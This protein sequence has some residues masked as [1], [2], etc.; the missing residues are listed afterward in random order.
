MDKQKILIVTEGVQAAQMIESAFKRKKEK[1]NYEYYDTGSTISNAS[2][3]S[4]KKKNNNDLFNK[5][6][7]KI[8][9]DYSKNY[10]IKTLNYSEVLIMSDSDDNG[11]QLIGLIY[12]A[13]VEHYPSLLITK[14]VRFVKFPQIIIKESDLSFIEFFTISDFE[15]YQRTT[16]AAE[17]QNY[18]IEW[19]RGLATITPKIADNLFKNLEKYIIYM[20][21]DANRDIIKFKQ[22]FGQSEN[23]KQYR[24]ESVI[25]FSIKIHENSGCF[26]T[27]NY[28][29]NET[30]CADF[31]DYEFILHFY[32]KAIQTLTSMIDG[33]TIP[34]RLVMHAILDQNTTTTP[35]TVT[36]AG[37]VGVL[38]ANRTNNQLKSDNLSKTAASLGYENNIQ[39][40]LN[41]LIPTTYRSK[42]STWKRKNPRYTNTAIDSLSRFIFR[43]EDE[44]ILKYNSQM[45][46]K[47]NVKY[48]L[49]IIP[50]SIVNGKMVRIAIIAYSFIGHKPIEIINYLI[51]RLST[52][53][54][55]FDLMPHFVQYKGDIEGCYMNPCSTGHF[56]IDLHNR[57]II[58]SVLPFGM[59]VKLYIAKTFFKNKILENIKYD[60]YEVKKNTVEIQFDNENFKEVEKLNYE[61]IV[62]IC[63]LRH[64]LYVDKTMYCLNHNNVI[65]NYGKSVQNLID[66]YYNQRLNA[67]IERN[68]F[69][70]NLLIAK[71]QQNNMKLKY[72][73]Q[74]TSPVFDKSIINTRENHIA[75]IKKMNIETDPLKSF[76]NEQF[77]VDYEKYKYV[78]ELPTYDESILLV[79]KEL[80]EQNNE[81]QTI[82]KKTP[83][84]EWIK[85]LKELLTALTHVDKS[86]LNN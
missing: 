79:K 51:K 26:P 24:R 38:A 46:K 72:L 4:D 58:I 22:W 86:N 33:F 21:Y 10:N 66:N 20:K 14:Y 27:I 45:G 19:I 71:I 35:T 44:P 64:S 53:E 62:R 60:N 17:L 54:E 83:E 85:E 6:N 16:P 39:I 37:G 59:S 47:T 73:N 1:D 15:K 65:V 32:N 43:I 57:K 77:T 48:L 9:I 70:E 29:N 13:F 50:M 75:I 28:I 67:Y 56:Y 40:N 82:K 36:T 2:N 3:H 25:N 63:N 41:L 11:K 12:N 30:T 69:N 80:E 23:S 34:E 78:I 74:I 8:N 18:Q 55:K 84:N 61:G 42:D 81:L 52:G 31:L 7:L 68:I 5:I 49:P 76:N